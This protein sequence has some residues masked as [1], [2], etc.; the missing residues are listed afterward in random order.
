MTNLKLDFGDIDVE[1]QKISLLIFFIYIISNIT[2][3]FSN[4]I[5]QSQYFVNIIDI[6]IIS[7]ALLLFGMFYIRRISL[8]SA[9]LIFSYLITP[10]ILF[11]DIYVVFKALSNWEITIV[12]D[13][14]LMSTSII[15]T[16]F[17][18]DK[19]HIIIQSIAYQAVLLT[20]VTFS[21]GFFPPKMFFMNIIFVFGFSISV[22]IY[23]RDLTNTLM[24]KYLLQQENNNKEIKRY[25]DDIEALKYKSAHLQELLSSKERELTSNALIIAKHKEKC[26]MILKMM[27]KLKCLKGDELVREIRNIKSN[28]EEDDV[29]NS[30]NY[31][32]KS[33]EKVHPNFYKNIS[34]LCPGLSPTEKRLAA[35]IKLGMTSKQ[36]SSL[37]YNTVSSIDV[38]RSRLRK[39]LKLEREENIEIF[40]TN[41]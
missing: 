20:A 30:W 7:T 5:S 3:L 8:Q 12:R 33:F 41:L 37:T 28:L 32:Q 13:A 25:Q 34:K 6:V 26:N 11:S 14:F 2:I 15:V 38:S 19:K 23:K 4:L 17:L 39:K 1:M 9:T 36:I 16:G 35:F 21:Q 31:F 40:L 22:L 24:K 29:F 10:R 27:Q 18:C